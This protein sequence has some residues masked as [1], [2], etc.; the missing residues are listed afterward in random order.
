M[1]HATL[2]Q[3]IAQILYNKK[4]LDITVLHVGHLTVITDYMVIATGRS[5]LQVKALADDVDEALAMEGISLR[6]REGTG[7]GRWIVLDY[8]TVLVHIFH[9]EDR[10]FYH[11]ER[12]WED[13]QNRMQLPFMD[14]EK[15]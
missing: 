11:L 10:Q 5:T 15:A 7:E 9:P 12:L 4:A 1:D 8:G 14:E 3:K 2:A 6:A 13:G